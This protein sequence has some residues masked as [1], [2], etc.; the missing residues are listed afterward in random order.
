MQRP[1][2]GVRLV[3]EAVCIIKGVKPKRVPGEK[4]SLLPL[5]SMSMFKTLIVLYPEFESE[6]TAA[7]EMLDR[8]VGSKEQKPWDR[9]AWRTLVEAATSS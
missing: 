4:A 8:V 6:A 1:P 5:I 9:P 2:D 3:V 7:E